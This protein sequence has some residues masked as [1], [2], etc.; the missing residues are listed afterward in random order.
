MRVNY[1]FAFDGDKLCAKL[2]NNIFLGN[3]E[4]FYK[5]INKICV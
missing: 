2:L 4:I 5:V 3:N 1:Y